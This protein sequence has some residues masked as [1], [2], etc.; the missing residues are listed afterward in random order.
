MVSS[1]FTISSETIKVRSSLTLI[2][3]ITTSALLIAF[4]PWDESYLYLIF[5]LIYLEF[6]SL[7]KDVSN[8]LT[9]QPKAFADL[10]AN[11]PVPAPMIKIFVVL[12]PA[13]PP[14]G[15]TPPLKLLKHSAAIRTDA[16]PAISLIDLTERRTFL[17]F[18]IIKCNSSSFFV[19]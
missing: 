18:N 13:I 4:E 5:H 12:T 17:I 7:C 15:I 16:F 9:E 1:F 11:S 8:I 3:P 2:A 10:A 19:Y 14:K 6:R